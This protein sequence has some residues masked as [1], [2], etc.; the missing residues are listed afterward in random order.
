M[1][2]LDF[3]EQISALRETF[4]NIRSVVDVDRLQR[5]I[6]EL[7]EQAGAQDLWDD[8][9]HAQQVTSALSHRQ[10]ELKKI[11]DTEQRIDD[12]TE[13]TAAGQEVRRGELSALLKRLDEVSRQSRELRELLAPLRKV[14][15]K[16]A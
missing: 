16:A 3:N 6:A 1:V 11:T 13:E 4:G 8:V 9:E 5:E 2:E 14:V 7:S 15:A 12:L 10:S